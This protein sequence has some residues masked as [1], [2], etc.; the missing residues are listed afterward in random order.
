MLFMSF[1]K[2]EKSISIELSFN[3]I[4]GLT[5]KAKYVLDCEIPK[6]TALPY[7]KF[8]EDLIRLILL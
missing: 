4:S 8:F 7:P 2:V 6:L 5:V 1:T 3:K